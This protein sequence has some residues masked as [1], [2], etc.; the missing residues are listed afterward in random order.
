MFR[1]VPVPGANRRLGGI[2]IASS[3]ALPDGGTAAESGSFD[4]ILSEMVASLL[5][6]VLS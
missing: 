6:S 4:L 5:C 1:E 2:Y 3:T